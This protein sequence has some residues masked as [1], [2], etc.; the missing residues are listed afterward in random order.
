MRS[1]L[2]ALSFLFFVESSSAV[3]IVTPYAGGS[4]SRYSIDY[5]TN[6]GV[7]Y[8]NMLNSNYNMYGFFFG[9]DINPYISFEF[10]YDQNISR[11]GKNTSGEYGI[12]HTSGKLNTTRYDFIGKIPLFL[13]VKFLFILGMAQGFNTASIQSSSTTI[14]SRFKQGG[15]DFAPEYGI[16][17][18][19]DH[20]NNLFA[21]FEIRKQTLKYEGIANG[22]NIISIGAGYRFL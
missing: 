20:G 12:T 16:G 6:N 19:V 2:F 5:V 10:N 4:L 1:F 7:N 14:D 3:T 9:L 21:K 17:V 8:N 18:M 22:G 11:S 15:Y 13:D